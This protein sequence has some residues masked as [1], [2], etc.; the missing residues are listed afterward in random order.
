LIV[1]E[2]EERREEEEK[3]RKLSGCF[4]GEFLDTGHAGRQIF[5]RDPSWGAWHRQRSG[6]SV[7]RET[8]GMESFTGTSETP[9]FSDR[10]GAFGTPLRRICRQ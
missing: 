6:T 4:G 1:G 2:E 10:F 9:R 5:E 8:T 7:A 3:E